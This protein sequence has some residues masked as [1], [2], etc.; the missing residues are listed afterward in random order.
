M[1]AGSKRAAL[2]RAWDVWLWS[3]N[4]CITACCGNK[5]SSRTGAL[6]EQVRLRRQRMTSGQLSAHGDVQTMQGVPDHG[7]Y[8]VLDSL[9]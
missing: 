5:L 9:A 1:S 4:P 3:Q 7:V 2:P 6:P 8:R